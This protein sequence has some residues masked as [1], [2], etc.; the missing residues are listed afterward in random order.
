MLDSIQAYFRSLLFIR[1]NHLS[2]L[3]WFPI[4]ITVLVFYGGI[5]LTSI[6]TEWVTAGVQSWIVSIDWLGES[7][8]VLSS[9]IYWIIWLMLR[10][11][12]YF[13]MAFLGGSIILLLMSPLLTYASELVAEKM[14]AE[15]PPFSIDRFFH[16]LA[17][18]AGLAI[19]NGGIQFILTIVCFL[20]GFIPIVGLVSPFL[21]FGVN[22]YF[23]GYNFM[24]YTLERKGLSVK[25]SNQFV[26]AEKFKTLGLGTPFA[27]WMLIPFIGPIT[28]GFVAL[29]ATVASTL[30]LES[31]DFYNKPLKTDL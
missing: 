15:V 31:T 9:I 16:D 22:A 1:K 11:T 6:A 18:A 10:I 5:E 29:I 17:R 3:F 4:V 24:D 7:K 25:E 27:L 13:F 2:W 14:G 23:F 20:I 30:S 8:G 21:M 28:S 26:F 19:K 12:L